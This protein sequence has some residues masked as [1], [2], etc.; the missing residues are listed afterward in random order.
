MGLFSSV[1]R[2]VIADTLWPSSEITSVTRF[3][4]WQAT[5]YAA[6]KMYDYGEACRTQDSCLL[7]VESAVP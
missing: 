7:P 3:T 2:A 6:Q 1:A 4:G 5:F